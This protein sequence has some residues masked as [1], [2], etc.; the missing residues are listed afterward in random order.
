MAS[1][2]ALVPTEDITRSILV[3]RGHRALLD[4]ELAAL[5]GVTTKRLNE[6]V[7]RNADRFPADFI[8]RL[9][10]TETEA[11]NRSQNATG[12]QKHRDPR[13]SPYAFTEHGAIMAAMVL[14]SPR[15]VEINV[16]T[17]HM[18]RRSAAARLSARF[19]PA[20]AT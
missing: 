19:S 5:Y 17:D 18:W 16:A 1:V 3:L 15:A 11:L 13:S 8:F 10:R 6:Q 7:K 12:S 4:S 2:K 20:S 14:N 9:T